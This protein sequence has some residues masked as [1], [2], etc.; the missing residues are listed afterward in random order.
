M[1]FLAALALQHSHIHTHTVC[2]LGRVCARWISHSIAHLVIDITWMRFVCNVHAFCSDPDF[3]CNN[4]FC[5]ILFSI[6]ALFPT[7]KATTTFPYQTLVECVNLPPLRLCMLKLKSFTLKSIVKCVI[8]LYRGCYSRCEHVHFTFQ[9]KW[10]W[11]FINND[12][13]WRKCGMKLAMECEKS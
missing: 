4:Y 9:Y 6:F 13:Y 7:T 2:V 10:V 12:K 5:A 1:C 11:N 3:D 8:Y